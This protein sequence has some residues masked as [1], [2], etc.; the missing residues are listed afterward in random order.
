METQRLT[1]SVRRM[2]LLRKPEANIT[3]RLRLVTGVK[4]AGST[5]ELSAASLSLLLKV[6]GF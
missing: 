4:L 2:E 5:S 6:A 3:W 1:L